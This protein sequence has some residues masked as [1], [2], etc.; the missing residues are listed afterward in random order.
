[1]RSLAALIPA[2]VLMTAGIALR[3]LAIQR[4]GAR[5][6]SRNAVGDQA[7]LETAGVYRLLAH[8]SEA[9]LLSLGAGAALLS[10]SPWSLALL[11]ALYA[12]ATARIGIEEA[13]LRN[14]YGCTYKVYRAGRFD[15]FPSW[16]QGP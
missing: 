1:M 5:F 7:R 13:T 11:V 10:A 3:A 12:S 15:P 8:P 9:G 2:L 16:I 6:S 4:L 14:R